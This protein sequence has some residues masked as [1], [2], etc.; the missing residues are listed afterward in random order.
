MYGA[1]LDSKNSTGNTALHVCAV[2]NQEACARLL[3]SRGA[4]RDAANHANQNPY[5]VIAITIQITFFFA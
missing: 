2:N 4:N 5:Q 3:L 1:E